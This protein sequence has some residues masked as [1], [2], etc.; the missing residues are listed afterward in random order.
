MRVTYRRTR[1]FTLIELLV[2]IAIIGVLVA[3]LLPAV[4]MAREA[5][6]RARCKNNLKQIGLALHNYHGTLRVLPFGYSGYPFTNQGSLWGW[7]TMLLPNLDQG[8]LY[9]GLGQ[10]TGGTNG[11]GAPAVGFDAVM[12][13]FNPP[14]A[15]LAT[16]LSVFRCPSDT[17]SGTL[18]IPAGGINGS[19]SAST[20]VFGRA[21]Y[22]GVMGAVYGRSSGLLR[23]DGAFGESS[24]LQFEDF[25][26]G[27]THTF[28]VGERRAP[29][30]IGS[31]FTGGDTIWAGASDD[32]FSGWQGF[33]MHLG[34]CDP[35]SPLNQKAT[36]APSAASGQPYIAFSS[37]HTGGAHFLFGDGAVR[38]IS[39]S[40]GT[41]PVG[42][43]GSTYQNL[44][45]LDDNQLPGDY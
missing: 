38:F 27:L 29:M 37:L 6:R 12:T 30:A 43:A 41:G 4:Q 16:N 40:I 8:P 45:T 22:P 23:T 39:D 24:S 7:G 20:S 31:Q 44:A 36:V 34:S 15:L 1:G 26:D 21:N 19:P 17:G 28:L 5:A 13:S 33:S 9:S 10:T 14:C 25:H 42:Q 18:T 2:V 11:F 32:N 3:L 35:M